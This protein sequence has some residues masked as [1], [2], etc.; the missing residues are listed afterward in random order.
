MLDQSRKKLRTVYHRGAA[1]E[2]YMGDA[3][4][5]DDDDFL[6][7]MQGV[8]RLNSE[9]RA[10]K[11]SSRPR[12]TPQQ[13]DKD[14]RQAL[15]ELMSDAS[16][17]RDIQPGDMLQFARDGVQNNT[18]RKLKRG[19]YRIQDELDL[20][21]LTVKEA[22]QLLSDFLIEMQQ[23][24]ITSVRIIHGK[25]HHSDGRGPVLKGNVAHW[26]TQRDEVLA[27]CS[28]RPADGGTGALYVLLRRA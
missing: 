3:N 25:G 15:A 5:F 18:V 17:L 27:Y 13:R 10:P 11:T 16:E 9:Q 8:R 6:S 26:L 28:A 4:D 2:V 7:A 23:R 14:E 21:G 22:R 1:T 12:P 19:Q 20:H 24:G